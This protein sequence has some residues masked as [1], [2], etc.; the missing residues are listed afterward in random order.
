MQS[1]LLLVMAAAAPG[2]A[3]V[4]PLVLATLDVQ[5]YLLLIHMQKDVPY[6]PDEHPM[7]S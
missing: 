5:V 1:L 6:E 3:P 7:S 4:R 2:C